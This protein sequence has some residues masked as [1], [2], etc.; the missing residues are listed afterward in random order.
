MNVLRS[1]EDSMVWSNVDEAK[2]L[3]MHRAASTNYNSFL[4]SLGQKFHGKNVI[5]TQI[6]R[7]I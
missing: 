7:R 2:P 4:D 1:K 5:S 6:L 3:M